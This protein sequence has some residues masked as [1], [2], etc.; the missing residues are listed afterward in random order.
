[1]SAPF[2]INAHKKAAP[3]QW[4]GNHQQHSDTYSF[5][6]KAQRQRMLDALI[7]A[8]RAGVCSRYAYRELG[9]TRPGMTAGKLRARGHEIVTLR[10]ITGQGLPVRYVLIRLAGG[11]K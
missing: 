5:L 11:E 3:E 1:M 6:P 2:H 8:G 7:K 9:I 10:D 4:S